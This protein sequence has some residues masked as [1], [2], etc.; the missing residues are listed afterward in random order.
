MKGDLK[1]KH[2][3]WAEMIEKN[4]EEIEQ[5]CT[6]AFEKSM[7]D[8]GDFYNTYAVL[9][10]ENGKVNIAIFSS[11]ADES[12]NEFSGKAIRITSYQYNSDWEDSWQGESK[13]EDERHLHLN[14]YIIWYECEGIISDEIDKRI[15][16]EENLENLF[17]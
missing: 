7:H 15:E 12:S 5:K 17:I 1:M 9:L 2:S 3:E 4:R 16:R 13:T 8:G 11:E 6:E 10:D 14:D